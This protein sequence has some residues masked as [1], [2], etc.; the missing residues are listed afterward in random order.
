M[1]CSLW[2]YTPE[3]DGGYCAGDCDICNKADDN[4]AEEVKADDE[5]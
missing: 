3:C 1:S 5:L 4:I 2:A